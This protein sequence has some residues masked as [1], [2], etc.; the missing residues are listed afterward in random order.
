MSKSDV[1]ENDYLLLILNA[2]AITNVAQNGT[3]PLTSLQLALHTADPGESGSETT[4][5]ANYGAYARKAVTR[6]SAGFT[7]SGGVG[8]LVSNCD[9]AVAT[10][11]SNTISFFH[12]GTAASGTG[13]ILYSG[14]VTPNISVS[15]GIG[16]RLAA[17][18]I[19][20]ED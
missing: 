11:L 3:S 13:K 19:I 7:V 14:T 6:T 18:S 5:E 8:S 12:V 15:T 20:T 2:T 4:S 1:F 17:G 10:S 16:P 9:F